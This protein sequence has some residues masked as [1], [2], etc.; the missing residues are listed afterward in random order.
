MRSIR[1]RMKKTLAVMVA[2]VT[3]VMSLDLSTITVYAENENV[4]S[5]TIGETTTEY[6]DI[7]EAF[8]AATADG[9]EGATVKL[10][11]DVELNYSSYGS[12]DGIKQSQGTVTLDL[13]GHSL[14]Q[15]VTSDSGIY[16][17]TILV[18]GGALT[19]RDS[20]GTGRIVQ[21]SANPAV[22]QCGG[23]Q[24]TIEGGTIEMT[25][26]SDANSWNEVHNTYQN[27]GAC[28]VWVNGG[29]LTVNGGTIGASG[30]AGLF[31]KSAVVKLSGGTFSRINSN[32]TLESMLSHGHTLQYAD[33]SESA[34]QYVT[35][36]SVNEI[37]N[38]KVV[39][40]NT[41]VKYLDAKR[42]TVTVA[43]TDY[44]SI[45]SESSGDL[46]M[47]AGGIYV[48]D[49]TV[50]LDSLTAE[51]EN[52]TLILRDGASLTV[53]GA[54][55][56]NIALYVQ[57]F[58]AATGT[59]TAAS[60]ADTVTVP[61]GIKRVTTEESGRVTVSMCTEHNWSYT[62]DDTTDENNH[63]MTCTL[64]QTT[65]SGA[66]SYGT[67]VP[68]TDA[69]SATH[70]SECVCGKTV[71][72]EHNMQ[73]TDQHDGTHKM[74]CTDC[75]YTDGNT[76]A[77]TDT[78]DDN[79]C[80]DCGIT[81]VAEVGGVC[82]GS[83]QDA[84]NAIGS[85]TGTVKLRDHV[86]R[87]QN[88][89][90]V[91][92][93]DVTLEL[94]GKT[95]QGAGCGGLA[96]LLCVDGGSVTVQNGTVATYSSSSEA[97]YGILVKSGSLTVTDACVGGG[98]VGE[99]IY[100]S[101]IHVEGG[102]VCIG[103][104]V[105][106]LYG[107]TTNNG[108]INDLLADGLA[109]CAYNRET[110]ERGA[111]QDG[112]V[113]FRYDDFVTAAHT[114]DF[115]ETGGCACGVQAAASV[116]GEGTTVTYTE[117]SDALAAMSDGDTMKLLSDVTV[118]EPLTFPAADGQTL[119]LNGQ[120]LT[121]TV[122][123][124]TGGSLV[125]TDTDTDGKGKLTSVV[126]DGGTITLNGGS[127]GTVSV[128][129]AG[130]SVADLLGKDLAFHSASGTEWVND[131][132]VVTVS[133][134]TV[135]PAPL[136]EACAVGE[137]TET[138]TYGD[139]FTLNATAEISSSVTAENPSVTYA[140]YE[141]KD[142]VTTELTGKTDASCEITDASAGTHTYRCG[143]T[144]NGYTRY[145][146][147]TVTL[148]KKAITVSID[149]AERFYGEENPTFTFSLSDDASLV[150]GDTKDDL[151]IT[152]TCEA[153][154][155]SDVTAD[156]YAIT[157]TSDSENYDVTFTDGTLTVKKA[158]TSVVTTTGFSNNICEKTYG[159][160][161][162]SLCVTASAVGIP[163]QY[164]I[165]EQ[166]VSGGG[167]P[168][169]ENEDENV[170]K[171]DAETGMVTFLRAGE[172]YIKVSIPETKNYEGCE[173]SGTICV[174]AKRKTYTPA[175]KTVD[176]YLTGRDQTG[177]LTDF[178]PED[179]GDKY[180]ISKDTD[181]T[182][183]WMDDVMGGIHVNKGDVR[184]DTL[185]YTI[186]ADPGVAKNGTHTEKFLV[187]SQNY[188]N[189]YVTVNFKCLGRKVYS[190]TTDAGAYEVIRNGKTQ[191]VTVDLSACVPEDLDAEG[192][193]MTL[194]AYDAKDVLIQG[195]VGTPQFS[196]DDGTVQ[197]PVYTDQFAGAQDI[198]I[199]IC[200]SGDYKNYDSYTITAKVS[201][202]D[203]YTVA[204][205]DTVALSSDTLT[206]GQTLSELTFR[207]VTFVRS[208]T[209]TEVSGTLSWSDPTHTPDTD[210]TT[211]AWT[212]TPT[213]SDRY[214]T[215]TG[216]VA[217]TVNK[218]TATFIAPKLAGLSYRADG[219]P[220]AILNQDAVSGYDY[221]L[222]AGTVTDAAGNVL[223]GSWH[224]GEPE[225]AAATITPAVG[226]QT[227]KIWYEFD[228][229]ADQKH[230]AQPQTAFTLT[231]AKAALT[232]NCQTPA[233]YTHGDYL[234]QKQVTGT[235]ESGGQPVNGT[236]AW[237]QGAT[238]LDYQTAASVDGQTYRTVA[239][240][241]IFTPDDASCYETA[242]TTLAVSVTRA[243]QAPDMPSGTV[244]AAKSSETLAD[245]TLLPDGWTW[246]DASQALPAAGQSMQAAV[247]YIGADRA[248]YVTTTATVTVQKADCD[249]ANTELQ[250]EKAATCTAQGY[251][252]DL[253]CKDCQ[254]TIRT[255]TATAIDPD[256]HTALTTT[257][258]KQPTTGAEGEKSCSCADCHSAWTE[259]IAK[260]SG[261]L[262]GS[263][264]SSGGYSG[265]GSGSP[266]TTP[267][268]ADEKAPQIKD[269]NG[270]S[271]W[272]AIRSELSSAKNGERITVQMNGASGV[273]AKVLQSIRGRN[274]SVT[275][276]LKNGVT[277]TV[278]G[279]TL[280]LFP[281]GG[282][283]EY[284]LT[285]IWSV[286]QLPQLLRRTGLW[287]G[288]M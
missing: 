102:T 22:A 285:F 218:A 108:T 277:V 234:Y 60:V 116:T 109:Y 148:G 235:A 34:G 216:T 267:E 231:V 111:V 204:A 207:D 164:E 45:D 137:I 16:V 276:E 155:T 175:V 150:D 18:E 208:G 258:T 203:K 14:S 245:V 171:I 138:L 41:P 189:F 73:C 30:K 26:D 71:T 179:L 81:F 193:Q 96:P 20:V 86:T 241:V 178:L 115:S 176:F 83:L 168:V 33:G 69:E 21:P 197:F 78:D 273:P 94:N 107:I 154:A 249:H 256:N 57:S 257:V 7:S 37:S 190:G 282:S 104:N 170:V 162:F 118:T 238:R 12:V 36:F 284:P 182:V 82:Y 126:A 40:G 215:L 52:V 132:T 169:S 90:T 274:V 95:W 35:D 54:V 112:S 185:T 233:A 265:G 145:A 135:I 283:R 84:V 88:T 134:V 139:T 99:N 244:L 133:D 15:Q 186:P 177:T 192:T 247:S 65:D 47:T 48:V 120:T 230:Y 13:A 181:S 146:E 206:Y 237:K 97:D 165:T 24:V 166:T 248:C 242:E 76:A 159:D 1:Q 250:N 228:N 113:G 246:D 80:D 28:A 200:P 172:A 270:A 222:T 75:G 55:S 4:A 103:E 240:T 272:D 263:G 252:G 253:Y 260:L 43:G 8:S 269:E 128:Q 91:K 223:A 92:Q 130:S 236:F 266:Q 214:Q 187:W 143:M 29:T 10:L 174:Q 62:Y 152:L 106:L 173:L 205:K 239:C 209:D 275:F 63:T 49:G 101:A 280:G 142:G 6:T 195:A 61:V 232:L 5:V 50:T 67:P 191:T 87:N 122:K 25:S 151:A 147:Q 100:F 157:G 278:N 77:H 141:V 51:S 211:A 136:T 153:T 140:W 210:E 221:T 79:Q 58:G 144:L 98:C 251:T 229:A 188:E 262:S 184:I 198:T 105:V 131:T 225:N 74:L 127:F 110:H 2:A 254:Q 11:K 224:W 39:E 220:E 46:T 125:I 158:K 287:R 202:L 93:G 213:E 9:V 271:G 70:T 19:I 281:F 163:L 194:Q 53:S 129:T 196:W 288:G 268:K 89:V 226:T 156:G 27:S 227:Q 212:F 31:Q 255:G 23:A 167:L 121:G 219:Y 68:T 160:A 64:C 119:D 114:H 286:T 38:V 261:G 44:T 243:Q 201:L 117:L 279:R 42:E 66:H 161:P 259:P 180:I 59:L 264:S 32:N 149:A 56:G 17:S 199:K 123:V 85:G 217:I 124:Q 3:V 183:E 72:S